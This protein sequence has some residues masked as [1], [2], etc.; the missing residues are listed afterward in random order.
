MWFLSGACLRRSVYHARELLNVVSNRVW[1]RLFA[2][3]VSVWFADV[4]THV[5]GVYGR[6][7]PNSKPTPSVQIACRVVGLFRRGLLGIHF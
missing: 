2:D 1:Q 5:R 6:S 4:V 7:V 3:S